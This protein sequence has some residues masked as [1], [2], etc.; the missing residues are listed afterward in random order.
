MSGG[1]GVAMLSTAHPVLSGGVWTNC[2]STHAD[3]SIASLQAAYTRM[4]TVLNPRGIIK[5]FTPKTLV[6][7]PASRWLMRELLETEKTP[8]GSDNTKNVVRDGIDG[9]VWSQMTLG[10]GKW[11]LLANKAG[12]VGQKG[13]TL[14]CVMRIRPQ[15]DRDTEFQT[16]DRRYKGRFRVAFGYPDARGIDGSTGI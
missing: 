4:E 5:S 16:G 11:L 15:F 7:P 2:P 3:L 9:V 10:S 14:T 1:D 13:H 6:V 12:E 8:Y